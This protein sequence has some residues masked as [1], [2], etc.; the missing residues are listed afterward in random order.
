LSIE[1]NPGD[2]PRFSC[3][4]GGQAVLAMLRKEWLMHTSPPK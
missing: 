1:Q 2:L 3:L 4:G